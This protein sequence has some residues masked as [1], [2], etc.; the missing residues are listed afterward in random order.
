VHRLDMS[1][2]RFEQTVEEIFELIAQ[3]L[4]LQG[5]ILALF[6]SIGDGFRGSDREIFDGKDA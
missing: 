3:I 4:F 6:K 1:A 2:E 5:T